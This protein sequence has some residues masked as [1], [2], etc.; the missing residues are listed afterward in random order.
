[1]IK[2]DDFNSRYI[3]TCEDCSKSTGLF[4]YFCQPL[5][6]ELTHTEAKEIPEDCPLEG[7][8]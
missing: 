6:R 2:W 7:Q 1:M 8:K 4:I 5:E 3:D